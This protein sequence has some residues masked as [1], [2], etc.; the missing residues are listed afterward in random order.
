MAFEN[1]FALVRLPAIATPVPRS[2]GTG[3]TDGV[4]DGEPGGLYDELTFR[5]FLAI[6][7]RRAALVER[8]SLVL[9]V[10]L[11]TAPH[12]PAIGSDLFEAL[13]ESVRDIDLIGWYR[14]GRVAA[15]LFAQ[16]LDPMPTQVQQRIVE[17]I[18]KQLARR[19]PDG[20]APRPRLRLVEFGGPDRLY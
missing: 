16:G 2:V 4:L 19:F 12:E 5:H 9:L 3:L 1:L 10:R 20:A 8:K 14:Q 11:E 7:R 17:R 15:V 18:K 6:E 13:E